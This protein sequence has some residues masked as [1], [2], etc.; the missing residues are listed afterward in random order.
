MTTAATA[1]PV[2]DPM[3][4][5]TTTTK[6][7]ISSATRTTTAAATSTSRLTGTS[8]PSSAKVPDSA[9]GPGKVLAS[10]PQTPDSRAG[11]ASPTPT[12]AST[13]SRGRVYRGRTTASSST[14]AASVPTAVPNRTASAKP[15]PP[16]P[17]PGSWPEAAH[18]VPYAPMESSAPCA[19]LSTS[20]RPK[21]S[22][23]PDATRK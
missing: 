19:K 10:E 16:G 17:A 15:Q 2:T 9:S 7:K 14:T 23:S 1:A 12:V 22:E 18:Q 4:P 6:A 11:T 21:I 5:V 13:C 8:A 20:I 3:P